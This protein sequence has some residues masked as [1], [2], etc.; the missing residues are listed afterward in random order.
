VRLAQAEGLQR[1]Y[2]STH[3]IDLGLPRP[4]AVLWSA[5]SVLGRIVTLGA[6]D[7]AASEHAAVFKKDPSRMI[8]GPAV[9]ARP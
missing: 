4:L 3:E 9:L 2:A 6:F 8:D 5:A 7:P 1:I